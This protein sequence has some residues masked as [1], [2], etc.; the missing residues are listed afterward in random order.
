MKRSLVIFAAD[1][2]T[3]AEVAPKC[4]FRALLPCLRT[5]EERC[6]DDLQWLSKARW[7]HLPD[8]S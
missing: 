4:E 7:V 8:V 5:L 6:D 1:A 2:A 3:E